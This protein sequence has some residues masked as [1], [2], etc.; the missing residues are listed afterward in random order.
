MTDSF[1]PFRCSGRDVVPQFTVFMLVF[2]GGCIPIPFVVCYGFGFYVVIMLFALAFLLAFGL[3][4]SI[5]V[6]RGHV[7]I[8]RNWFGIPYW[9]HTGRG[10]EDVYYG[11]DWG[12]ADGA[13][14]VVVVLEG[15][16]EFHIGSSRSMHHLH[17]ALCRLKQLHDGKAVDARD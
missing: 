12:E 2:G 6:D 11:G 10:L 16:H 8:R 13:S 7:A 9:T 3:R 15:G 5:V 14:G 4:F 17:T 1:T